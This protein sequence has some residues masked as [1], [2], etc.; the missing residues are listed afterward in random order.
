MEN[1]IERIGNVKSVKSNSR[2]NWKSENINKKKVYFVITNIG[3]GEE[4][5]N[6]LLDNPIP[7]IRNIGSQPFKDHQFPSHP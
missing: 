6:S 2:I 1:H 3:Q 7:L 4:E 5:K